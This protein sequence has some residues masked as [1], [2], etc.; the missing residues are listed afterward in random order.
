LSRRRKRSGHARLLPPPPR[1]K[2][3]WCKGR[4]KIMARLI[5]N[6]P[7]RVTSAIFRNA[8]L[9]SQKTSIAKEETLPPPPIPLLLP[10]SPPP[11]S[12]SF[13]ILPFSSSLHLPRILAP[14]EKKKKK[15]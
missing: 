1:A 8:P 4:E 12:I 15:F 11:I 10:F 13:A 14:G 2:V 9:P 6:S 3:R 7:S 5:A